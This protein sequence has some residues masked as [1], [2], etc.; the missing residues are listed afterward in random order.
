MFVDE[1]PDVVEIVRSRELCD[2]GGE[3][4]AIQVS[5]RD[6]RG[7]AADFDDLFGVFLGFG[8]GKRCFCFLL[9]GEG[10]S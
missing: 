2:G 4:D 1:L 5:F 7:C 10:S 8:K 3:D 9:G 6:Q